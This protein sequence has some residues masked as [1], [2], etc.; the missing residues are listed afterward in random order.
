[1]NL[2]W[3][4][5]Q[6]W[7]TLFKK[8][9]NATTLIAHGDNDCEVDPRQVP[10][11]RSKWVGET[12]NLCQSWKLGRNSHKRTFLVH[13]RMLTK[14]QK[15]LISSGNVTIGKSHS[16]RP[17]WDLKYYT[18]NITPLPYIVQWSSMIVLCKDWINST[19]R[20]STGQKIGESLLY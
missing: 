1:M 14:D 19:P 20:F 5:W 10:R 6:N 17:L 16:Y 12:D 8:W 9:R 3:K 15:S 7:L 2:N 13:P 11:L 18:F 4:S